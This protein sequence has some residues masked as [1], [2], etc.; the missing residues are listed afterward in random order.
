MSV[1]ALD[2]TASIGSARRRL[3]TAFRQA[4][5]DSPE[6]DARVLLSFALDLDHAGLAAAAERDLAPADAYRIAA[7]GAR[8][9]ARESVASIVGCKEFWGL[10]FR[11][12]SATLIPR[13]ETETVVEA[14][15]QA[16]DAG[17]SR[18]R[19]LRIADLGTGS[20]CILIALLKQLPNAYGI[21][22]DI[23]APALRLAQQ[24]AHALGFARRTRFVCASFTT[25][26]ADGFDLVVSN[27]PYIA[28]HELGAL[29]PEVQ[30]EPRLALDGGEDGLAAYRL[31]IK[32]AWRLLGP[33][34][35]LVLELGSGQAPAVE[36]L[37]AAARLAARAPVPDLAG[38]PRAIV[39]IA[40]PMR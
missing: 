39:A 37:L 35:A 36:E 21:G 20:G 30:R 23:S 8:R 29:A 32:D 1:T 17:G 28:T 14:A 22:T 19:P 33:N 5:L 12:S 3:A 13:P 15:L 38:I 31:I 27:P 40:Q 4:G 9:L 24:N 11:V 10:P 16:V 25:A 34:G 26:L 2:L 7:L 6:L 18:A